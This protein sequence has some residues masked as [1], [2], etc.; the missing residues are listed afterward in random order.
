[1]ALDENDQESLRVCA[2]IAMEH[3]QLDSWFLS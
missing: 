1:M 3:N 2:E